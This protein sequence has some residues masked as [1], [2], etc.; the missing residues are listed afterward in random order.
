VPDT[1]TVQFISSHRPAIEAGEYRLTVTQKVS[2]EGIEKPFSE[3]YEDTKSFVVQGRRFS[4][5]PSFVFSVYPPHNARGNF[6][7]FLPHLILRRRS[8][9]WERSLF[10][11]PSG[12]EQSPPWL[13][14]LLIHAGEGLV[15]QEAGMIGDLMPGSFEYKAGA[16]RPSTRTA[17]ILSY[18]LTKPALGESA[19]DPCFLIDIPVGLFHRIA[20]PADDLRWLAHARKAQ[21]EFSVIVGNRLPAGGEYAAH[22]VCLEG[23]GRYLPGGGGSPSAYFASPAGLGVRFV[24]LASLRKWTFTQVSSEF[25]FRLLLESLDHRRAALR[26]P[27]PDASLD[28]RAKAA[29]S[30]GLRPLPHRLRTGGKALSWYRGPFA[31]APV[32]AVPRAFAKSSDAALRFDPDLKMFDASCAA[33]WQLGQLLALK[34]TTFAAALLAWKKTARERLG[35]RPLRSGRSGPTLQDQLVALLRSASG[36]KPETRRRMLRTAANPVASGSSGDAQ[37]SVPTAITS[38]LGQLS[39]FEEVPFLYLAPDPALLPSESIRFFHVDPNW[40]RALLEGAFSLGTSNPIDASRDEMLI[41]DA[42]PAEAD[43]PV[44]GFLLRSE[45]VAGWPGIQVVAWKQGGSPL[46]VLRSAVLPPNVLL[47]LFDGV[48]SRLELRQAPEGVHFGFEKAD[49]QVEVQL[50]SLRA[51]TAGTELRRPDGR[52]VSAVGSFQDREKRTIAVA[53]LAA[54]IERELPAYPN[55]P[56]VKLNSATFAVQMIEGVDKVAFEVAGEE[57]A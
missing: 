45:A 37:P 12:D 54:A 28:P 17:Q 25:G 13:A 20:P 23:M 47:G 44:S 56:K 38:W 16:T 55:E 42:V 52:P 2:G 24:R 33:A 7:R 27:P 26:P 4:L 18:G 15:E 11:Q 53:A 1:T 50:R 8:F 49:A 39:L 43:R 9:L 10:G 41:P 29:H 6:S 32:P 36:A 31:P 22:L 30:A 51:G 48:V 21:G 57:P 35:P 14:L 3:K 5:D 19:A 34:S 40:V 46:R